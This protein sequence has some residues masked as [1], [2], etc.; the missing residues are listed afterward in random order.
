MTSTVKS[1]ESS[2]YFFII[3]VVCGQLP[4]LFCPSM[5]S[6]RSFSAARAGAVS[7]VRAVQT[8][9]RRQAYFMGGTPRG[10]VD[11]EGCG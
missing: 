3:G 10:N 11:E 5:M 4:W 7:I 1:P 6:A 8:V 2:R 9:A